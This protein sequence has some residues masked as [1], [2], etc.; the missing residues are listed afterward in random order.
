MLNVYCYFFLNEYNFFTKDL[1]YQVWL[2]NFSAIVTYVLEVKS[3][4]D[5]LLPTHTHTPDIQCNIPSNKYQIRMQG[6]HKRGFPIDN[7][8]NVL[9]VNKDKVIVIF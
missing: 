3:G 5:H 1:T 6:N 4:C 9:S 2:E 8:D 7:C